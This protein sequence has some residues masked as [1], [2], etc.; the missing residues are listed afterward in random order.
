VNQSSCNYKMEYFFCLIFLICKQDELY[1]T[2]D[3][4]F[5]LYNNMKDEV[6]VK[7][8]T[9]LSLNLCLYV[10]CLEILFVL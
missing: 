3:V 6:F 8:N 7:L 1:A 10:F 5:K 2:T 9:S 4:Q